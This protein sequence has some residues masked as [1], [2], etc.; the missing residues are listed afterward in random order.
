MGY[1]DV[2]GM[3]NLIDK[4]FCNYVNVSDHSSPLIC[5]SP[6][7]SLECKRDPDHLYMK[8]TNELYGT[9]TPSAAELL[10]DAPMNGFVQQAANGAFKNDNLDDLSAIMY[11]F[12][13]IKVPIHQKL[14]SEYTVFDRWF[15]SLPGPTQPNRLFVHAGTSAG[16]ISNSVFDIVFGI[17]VRTIFDDLLQS[18]LTWKSYYH[19]LPSLAVLGKIRK[20]MLT[21]TK[22]FDSFYSDAK[23]GNLANYTFLEPYD[24]FLQ[25]ETM[26]SFPGLKAIQ[27]MVI[28]IL[29]K[30]LI[31][32]KL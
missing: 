8:V 7:Q 23:V 14:A 31:R 28:P 10:S 22:S 29:G 18:G 3:D 20:Q 15:A 11:G 17:N 4:T 5:T 16:R 30:V 26:G 32:L 25:L 1:V 24:R 6:Q 21:R 9:S 13:A 2:P 19:D 12:P 27:M